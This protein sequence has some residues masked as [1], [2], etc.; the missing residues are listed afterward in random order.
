MSSG[1]GGEPPGPN[2]RL[3]VWWRLPAG[4]CGRDD[5]VA[6]CRAAT[7]LDNLDNYIL[8]RRARQDRR[9]PP[10]DWAVRAGARPGPWVEGHIS[11]RTPPGVG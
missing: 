5:F 8:Q 7:R 6:L 11:L 1:Q 2:E 4:A 3:E 9:C 10:P